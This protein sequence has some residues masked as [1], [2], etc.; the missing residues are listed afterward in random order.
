MILAG[1]VG[2]GANANTN[3]KNWDEEAE[4]VTNDSDN[5]GSATND[6]ARKRILPLGDSITEGDPATY[7]YELFR[8]LTERGANFDYVGSWQH[9]PLPDT[10]TGSWDLDH[11]GHAGW[12]TEDIRDTLDAPTWL[13]AYTPDIALIHL[14]TNDIFGLE[15]AEDRDYSIANM[16]RIIDTLRISNPRIE[17][18]IAQILPIS[19]NYEHEVE[20]G[21]IRP[22]NSWVTL[23]N[24]ALS[25]LV[26][27]IDS[28][29][30]PIRLVDMNSGFGNA[31][32]PDGI[33]PNLTGA[34]KM[35][36]VWAEALEESFGSR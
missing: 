1:M 4:A 12:T 15:V 14:G 35:A 36:E 11:E 2:C 34:R 3:Q 23:Y 18:Y 7:R 5:E 10:Y 28:A 24:R 6:N 20:E 27:E 32:L 25:A 33:H 17:I 22:W 31:D 30:S 26:L 8:I 9:N 21:P 29:Q 19:S 13:G 16:R